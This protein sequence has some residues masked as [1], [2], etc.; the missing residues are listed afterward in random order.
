V[1]DRKVPFNY[2]PIVGFAWYTYEGAPVDIEAEPQLAIKFNG[3]WG[4]YEGRV[5]IRPL[6]L[7][8]P[9]PGIALPAAAPTTLR[10]TPTGGDAV[11]LRLKTPDGDRLWRLKDDGVHDFDPRDYGIDEMYPEEYSFSLQRWSSQEVD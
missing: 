3:E 6:D 1:A 8:E 4:P 11:Y 5:A 2:D 10:W 7:R 9:A